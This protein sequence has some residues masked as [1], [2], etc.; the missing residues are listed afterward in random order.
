MSK[1]HISDDARAD[2]AEIKAYISEGLGNPQAARSTAKKITQ[3]IRQ[4]QDFPLMGPPLDSIVAL[5]SEYRFLVAGNYLVFYR[6][7]GNDVY[8]DRVFYGRRNYPELLFGVT[9]LSE[10]EE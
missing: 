9:G 4:L 1:L 3:R 6:V 7:K 10:D 2:M 8:V 5:E